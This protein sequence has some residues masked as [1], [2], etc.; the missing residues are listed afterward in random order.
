[1]PPHTSPVTA[2]PRTGFA[3]LDEGRAGGSL[4]AMAHRGGARHPEL[5][6]AENTLHAFRHAA[7]LGYRYLET[8]VHATTDG[9]LLA[10]HDAVLDRVTDRQGRLSLLSAQ[11]VALARIAGAHA[12][13]TMAELLEELPEA[14]F[15]IDLK[16]A[17]SVAPLA[18]LV[19]RT[20]SHDR[21][22]IGS[23]SQS[24]LDRFRRLSRGRVA[25]SASPQEVALFVGSPSGRVS[26]LLTRGKV[27]ALQVPH[28]RGPVPVVTAALVRR[29]HAARAQVHVWT[30][31]EPDEM[32][33]LVDLGVDGLITDRTDVLKDV[34]VRRGLWKDPA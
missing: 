9:T 30:V 2:A 18:A 25:T 20:A 21:V 24:R 5:P 31:D 32:E 34:L 27:A 12:V 11:D 6:G 3:Y 26:R 8:D 22:C 19:D 14:R 29:A 1:M 23:F 10:F 33:E 13:P 7:A 28:R 16:S 17:A 4:I 15:N